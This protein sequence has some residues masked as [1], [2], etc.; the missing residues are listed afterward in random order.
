VIDF[1]VAHHS[2]HG[3]NKKVFFSPELFDPA[4][5]LV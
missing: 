1:G 4:G 3:P 2:G 5:N